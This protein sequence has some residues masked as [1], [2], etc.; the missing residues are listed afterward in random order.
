MAAGIARRAL[1]LGFLTSTLALAACGDK[2]DEDTGGELIDAGGSGDDVGV[3]EGT[4]PVVNGLSCVNTGIQAHYE[5][6][7]DTVTMAL[8]VDISDDDGDLH[9]Y[10]M[11]IFIDDEVDGVVTSSDSP[12]GPVNQTLN[13]E[14]CAGFEADVE[15]TLYLTGFQPDFDTEY[16]WGIILTDDAGY[17][18]DMFVAPCITPAQD[19]SDGT[20]AGG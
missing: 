6:G 10:R 1:A 5:T 15:L 17:E 13:V 18:S 20:G 7:E 2:D 14:E 4:I 19:G 12:F 9:Q 3:C 16:D 11:E 8:L